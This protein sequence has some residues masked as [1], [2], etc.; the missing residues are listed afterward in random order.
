M[1]TLDE[2]KRDVLA[3]AGTLRQGLF[4]H[5]KQ[6]VG[7]YDLVE[8]LAQTPC[9]ECARRRA[10]TRLRVQRVRKKEKKNAKPARSN[11]RHE[12][13]SKNDLGR[14]GRRKHAAGV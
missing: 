2:L 6:L 1:S 13:R 8:K 12:S 10:Q 9:P 5:Q 3:A 7:F 14:D 4:G 11:R